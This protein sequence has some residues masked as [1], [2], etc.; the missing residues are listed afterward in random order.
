MGWLEQS[1]FDAILV[2]AAAPDI[3]KCYIDQ[4]NVGGILVIPVG[5]VSSQVLTKVIK[6]KEGMRREDI[7][8]CRFVKLIG[9]H[10]WKVDFNNE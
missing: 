6:T 10:G 5:D 9:R 4:L 7:G 2:A 8:G 1:P 3:P